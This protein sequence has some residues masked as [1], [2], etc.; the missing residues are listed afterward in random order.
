MGGNALL[1][2]VHGTGVRPF[3]NLLH[4]CFGVGATIAP[5]V[6]TQ[7]RRFTEDI[8]AGYWVLAGLMLLVAVYMLMLPSPA[9][10]KES[11]DESFVPI[12][13]PFFLL[14]ALFFFLF[15]GL[16]MGFGEW[17]YTYATEKEIMTETNAGYL[18][19]V[20]WGVFT[21]GRLLTVPIAH[22]FRP[23][24]ILIW[25]AFGAVASGR[26]TLRCGLEP[27]DSD[28]LSQHPSQP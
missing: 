14:L 22:R 6:M 15:V 8:I 10:R 27:P 26:I 28:Y 18:N 3:M 20:F 2:W 24:T 25:N 12:N 17:I 1:V 21:A 16:E 19:S 23:R 13:Y 4:F 11:E 5:F 7:S 9:I